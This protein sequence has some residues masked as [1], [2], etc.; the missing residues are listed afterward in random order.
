MTRMTRM[1][2]HA[3]QL[4]TPY[5]RAA[6]CLLAAAL[7]AGCQSGGLRSD[8]QQVD[9]AATQAQRIREASE[10]AIK[11]KTAADK[12]D[13]EEAI[14]LNRRAIAMDATLAG[15]WNNLGVLLMQQQN[16]RDAIEA[17]SRAADLLP[18]DPR[19]YENIAHSYRE[20]GYSSDAFLYFNK[21]LER[22][23]NWLNSLRG[24]VACSQELNLSNPSLLANIR[25]GLLIES[26][27][28][29]RSVFNRAKLR[30]ESELKHGSTPEISY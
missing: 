20:A 4:R 6:A 8:P 7:A 13:V 25:R 19:P 9:P 26:D 5:A 1:T 14:D 17:F 16:Y 30:V 27:P 29:W 15:A 23:P 22:D 10:L 2:R 11:A 21:S 3:R 12:G 24:V 28:Q 18:A